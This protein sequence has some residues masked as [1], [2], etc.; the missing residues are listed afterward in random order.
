[1]KTRL[2]WLAIGFVLGFVF[3]ASFP[4]WAWGDDENQG[5]LWIEPLYSIQQGE[6]LNTQFN[7]DQRIR[8][9][10]WL[11]PQFQY[12]NVRN[13][14]DTNGRLD[15]EYHWNK[16]WTFEIGEG[17]DVFNYYGGTASISHEGHAGV[18]VR[19]W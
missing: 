6:G 16:L 7:I 4:Y 18:K 15:L 1:M 9:K 11:A 14:N 3:L 12:S 5:V 19:L 8:G 2:L 13:Y 17:Y 10:W